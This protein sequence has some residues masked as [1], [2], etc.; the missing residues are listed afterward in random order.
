MDRFRQPVIPDGAVVDV[1]QV[2]DADPR[3]PSAAAAEPA[4]QPRR[5]Q[6]PQQLQR[7]A[8]GG[9]HD[10]GADPDYA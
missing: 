7:A 5:K 4:T 10:A 2:V 9:L 3:Q 8:A 1:H 6:R